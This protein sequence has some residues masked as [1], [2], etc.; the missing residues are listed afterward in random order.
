MGEDQLAAHRTHPRIAEGLDQGADH[1]G[2]EALTRIGQH[3]DVAAGLRDQ[4]VQHGRLPAAPYEV[5]KSPHLGELL[6]QARRQYDFVVLDTP[7]I[8]LTQ[9]CRVI[10]KWVD[11]FPLGVAADK[12]PSKLLEEGL[13]RMEPS[14]IVGFVFN[15]D[16]RW[17]ARYYAYGYVESQNGDRAGWWRRTIVR[18]VA[19]FRQRPA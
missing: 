6:D 16:V 15:D 2:F 3:D 5:L 1:P 7:P 17:R 18:I 8:V 4:V 19:P 12:T 9:D 13:N 11:G 14:K 10:T